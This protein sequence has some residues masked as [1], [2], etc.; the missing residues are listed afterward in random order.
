LH[1]ARFKQLAG[2]GGADLQDGAFGVCAYGLV[3]LGVLPRAFG[4]D[5]G[6]YVRGRGLGGAADDVVEVADVLGRGEVW[7]GDVVASELGEALGE[8][9]M[10]VVVRGIHSMVDLQRI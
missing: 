1:V 7:V 4:V 2:D 5:V 8:L 10:S 3:D 6:V 9:C